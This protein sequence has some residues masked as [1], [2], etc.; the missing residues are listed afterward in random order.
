M[1][2]KDENNT[3]KSNLE[4]TDYLVKKI[5]KSKREALKFKKKMRRA[6]ENQKTWRISWKYSRNQRKNTQ[7]DEK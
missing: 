1:K 6:M 7:E 2:V 3:E 4:E 5:S